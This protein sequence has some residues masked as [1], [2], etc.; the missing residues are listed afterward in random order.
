MNFKPVA[1]HGAALIAAALFS[2]YPA[3]SQDLFRA[4]SAASEMRKGPVVASPH[5]LEEFPWLAHPEFLHSGIKP[6]TPESIKNNSALSN[7]PRIREEYPDLARSNVPGKFGNSVRLKTIRENSALAN[8][9]RM[10][11]EFPE[12]RFE[13]SSSELP[14]LAGA[15]VV[16]RRSRQ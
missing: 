5:A 2:S 1:T 4:A 12:L 16:L 9:P 11:E 3:R 15:N 7:S 8:S 10:V 6:A 13:I 14:R